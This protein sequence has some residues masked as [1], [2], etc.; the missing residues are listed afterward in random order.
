MIRIILGTVSASAAN[1]NQDPDPH[2]SIKLDP[3][4]HQPADDKPKYIE[5][6]LFEHF[7]RVEPLFGSKDP[8]PHKGKTS[9]PEQH[10]MKYDTVP[11]TGSGSAS[12]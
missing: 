6:S 11:G 7:S 10:Q 3:D 1:K 5:Y 2:Q 12:K 9:D 8:D 4:P